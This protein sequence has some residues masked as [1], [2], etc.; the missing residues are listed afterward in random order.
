[1]SHYR[2]TLNPKH[3]MRTRDY[4]LTSIIGA[5]S[6][7]LWFFILMDLGLFSLALRIAIG[8]AVPLLCLG[9][10]FV[11]RRLFHGRTFHKFVKFA[12]V[13]LLNTAIDL[14]IFD[15]LI[16]AT[17][18]ATG[19]WPITIFKSVGFIAALWNSYELN[20]QWTFDGDAAPS[21]TRREL[22]AFVVI[23]VVGFLLNV[24]A[25]SFIANFTPPLGLSQVRWDN[26]A[27]IIATALNLV[28]NFVGYQIFVFNAKGRKESIISP[29]V[30]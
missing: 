27:A 26:V 19:W 30:I 9:A 3:V 8:I 16:L 21:R 29:N 23:T 28:W 6:G 14:S 12:L 20:R 5:V 25:T 15:L 7:A 24:S 22:A 18:V 13:G 4:R 1:M 2:D 10:V 11:A 17:G